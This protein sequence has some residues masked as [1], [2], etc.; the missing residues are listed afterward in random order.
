MVS[1]AVVFAA[2][3]GFAELVRRGSAEREHGISHQQDSLGAQLGQGVTQFQRRSVKGPFERQ[4]VIGRE[5]NAR[6]TP[7]VAPG[8]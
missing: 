3:Y 6:T 7:A 2:G 8:T 5:T 4:G 1:L